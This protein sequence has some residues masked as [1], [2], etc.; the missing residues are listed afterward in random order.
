V[1]T[2]LDPE[3]D[4]P[5]VRRVLAVF[6]TKARAV[7]VALALDGNPALGEVFGA[8]EPL[9]ARR[10]GHGYTET[11]VQPDLLRPAGLAA[12]EASLFR[13]DA[14]RLP[15]LTSA[16]GLRILG[17]P[18]GEGT[19]MAV[20]REVKR[21]L[22]AGF[23][24]EDL[25]LLVRRWDEDAEVVLGVLQSWELPVTAPCR[26]RRLAREPAVSAL[27]LA[28]ELPVD[29]WEAS[30]VIRLLR[31]GRFRPD[32]P[33]IRSPDLP[34]RAAAAIRDR[35]VFRGLDALRAAL[36]RSDEGG[37]VGNSRPRFSGEVKALVERLIAE[38]GSLDRPGTW[39]DH[40]ARLRSM[41]D[42]LGLDRSPN[43]GPRSE[44]ALESV[45]LA[46]EDHGDVLEGLGRGREVMPL[47]AFAADLDAL[48]AELSFESESLSPGAV[49]MTTVDDAAGVRARC[50]LLINLS[51]GTF[52]TREAV[53]H[54]GEEVEAEGAPES[55][56]D[57]KP[58]GTDR[59]YA[60]EM[61]RFLRVV[62]SA[63]EELI[64]AYPTRDEKGQEVLAAGFLDDLK[65][66]FDP[67]ALE[68]V[69]ESHNR[70]HPALAGDDEADL[71]VAPADAR[72]RAVAL[73]C[74]RHDDSELRRLAADPRQREALEGV[75]V[76]LDVAELRF[77]HREFTA[78]DGRLGDP[79]AVS[80]VAEQFNA[81]FTFTPSQLESYLY[82]PFQFFMKFVL[83]LL[84]VEDRDEID[85][86]YAGR[87]ERVHNSLELLER[88]RL[89]DGGS[90]LELVEMVIKT[91]M[92]VELT[93]G[94][95]ADPGLHKIEARR[96]ERTL[97]SYVVQAA[98][99]ERKATGP[100]PEPRHFEVAFGD[101]KRDDSL[102][103]LEVGRGP[104]LVKI[105][106][107]ID[108]VDVLAS[109]DGVEFRV[110]D[111]KTGSCPSQKE[112]QSL[113]MVQLPL[114]ALAV[115][116]HLLAEQ[117]AGLHD[118]GYWELRE[119][120]YR[121]VGQLEWATLRE[122]LQDRIVAA[123]EWLRNGQFEVRPRRDDCTSHCDYS[124]VC[125]VAQVKAVRKGEAAVPGAPGSS[126]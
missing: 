16:K 112:V 108:R 96:L 80:A 3:D 52:P 69:H 11:I 63:D 119:K 38:V 106:G 107:K 68:D 70:F 12:V 82:C 61:A 35:R 30:T 102:P 75:A 6:E 34:A 115:E 44:Y 111:Y 24:P 40:L 85:E 113:D 110:I 92:S 66:L 19:G 9:R 54:A 84:P 65:R 42:R 57:G 2:V 17:A 83:G 78:H 74:T 60:L 94:S 27:R 28:L 33:E 58:S 22:E 4:I 88:T 45:W 126:Q 91:A 62:G 64:L 51:E 118:L 100:S 120:G 36:D 15:R 59:A 90:R 87:G 46:L 95:E 49:V 41:A 116:R 97:R 13:D 5:A 8:I 18:Q 43:G 76:A 124:L 55:G 103:S 26:P 23:A 81:D 48:V 20:A 98:A 93:G 56:T 72:V 121:P 21:R 117:K 109:A 114:Y 7:R 71:A 101:P 37:R 104:T 14:H 50:V 47:R 89:Q 29:G 39:S 99:D 1:V 73:A 105:R 53:E 79:A 122:K 125:R 25:L 86:D 31:H 67:P 123:V 10:L 32:W 77:R